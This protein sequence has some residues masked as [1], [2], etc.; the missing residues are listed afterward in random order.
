MTSENPPTVRRSR[1]PESLRGVATVAGGVTLLA[2]LVN[3]VLLPAGP[4]ALWLAAFFALLFLGVLIH[5]V[6]KVRAAA[7]ALG[8]RDFKQALQKVVVNTGRAK[9]LAVLGVSIVLL[10]PAHLLTHA[11]PAGG[12]LGSHVSLVR[13]AQDRLGVVDARIQEVAN[14]TQSIKK[15]TAAIKKDTGEI[16]AKLDNVKKETSDDPRKELANL[17]VA[18]STQS[19]VDSLKAGDARVV[20]LFLAGGMS[21]TV[22]HNSASAV[23]YIL[24]PRLPDPSPML[25]LMIEAGFDVNANLYDAYILPDYAD[26]FPP[27]FESPD[28]PDGY[29]SGTFEGPALLWLVIRSAYGITDEWDVGVIEF[30]RRHGADTKLTREFLDAL[31]SAWGD[32][33]TY[34]RV[35]AAVG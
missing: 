7:H 6:T 12:Q 31:R 30:L 2:A 22:L 17:G 21:P 11:A 26:Y 23:L 15:D 32:T 25:K 4:Y 10:L 18:W 16:K 34:Q 27:Y 19:F 24:Q 33:P 29:G 3:D 1:V 8:K 14:T 13:D 5:P 20:E 28:L 35:R 9:V